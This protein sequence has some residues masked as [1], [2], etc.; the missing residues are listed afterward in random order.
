MNLYCIVFPNNKKYVGVESNDGQRK[1]Y[2]SKGHK[3]T[4]VGRAI[5]KHGWNNCTFKYL[6]KN[7]SKDTCLHMEKK[8]ID[9]W[10]LQDKKFGYNVSAGGES[11]F[12][13]IRHSKHTIEKMKDSRKKYNLTNE[14]KA[15]ISKSLKNKK[16]NLKRRNNISNGHGSK[17]FEVFRIIKSIGNCRSK[18]FI[19]LETKYI[20]VYKNQ[21]LCA[22]E[23]NLKDKSVNSCLL[24]KIKTHKGY[25]F[26]FKEV[27]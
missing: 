21:R 6:I 10:Q 15:N 17:S 16:H 26:K 2:H 22:E 14:W 7:A 4:V 8:L 18:N 19:I 3:H 12:K 24:G 9:K 13:G 25:I 11:G 23:L 27:L 1:Q 5:K 20:G